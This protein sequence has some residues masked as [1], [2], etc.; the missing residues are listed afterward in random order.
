MTAGSNPTINYNV[1]Q[2]YYGAEKGLNLFESN[3]SFAVSVIGEKDK[4]TKYDP[5]YVR[6]IAQYYSY[7]EELKQNI[8]TEIPI[9]SCT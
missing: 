5:R 1:L 9:V 7:S 4:L 8:Y 6:M 2:N 3:H